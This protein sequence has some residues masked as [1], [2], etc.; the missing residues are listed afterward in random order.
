MATVEFETVDDF[1]HNRARYM[2]WAGLNT[3]DTD[4]QPLQFAG[5]ADKTVHV[6]GTFGGASVSFQASNDP[7]VLTDPGNAAWFTMDD[8]NGLPM[9]YSSNGGDMLVLNPRFTRPVLTGGNGTTDI[10]VII[11]CK[12]PVR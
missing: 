5:H 1:I 4:G 9:T 12:S 8:I 3:T 11:C 6:F 10:T 2:T 7:R